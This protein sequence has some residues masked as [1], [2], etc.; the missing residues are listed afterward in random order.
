MSYTIGV[1]ALNNWKY[2][3][4]FLTSI[5]VDADVLL[6]DNGSSDGTAELAKQLVIPGTGK[7]PRVVRMDT[8]IGVAAGWNALF[9]NSDSETLIIANNDITLRPGS[10][11]KLARAHKRLGLVVTGGCRVTGSFPWR[12][13][14]GTDYGLFALDRTLWKN[15]PFDEAYWPGYFEDCDHTIRI[16]KDGLETC[17]GYEGVFDCPKGSRTI[18]EGI[19]NT[20]MLKVMQR[21]MLNNGAL[22]R[23]KYGTKN[24]AFAIA[25]AENAA[26]DTPA[27]TLL[28][29]VNDAATKQHPRFGRV[30]DFSEH[31]STLHKLAWGYDHV[32]EMGVRTAVSTAAILSAQPKTHIAY[33]I[34]EH[35]QVKMLAAVQGK[36]SFSFRQQDVLQVDIE[37]TD[38]LFIDTLHT[39]KQLSAEF[40]RHAKNV[41]HRIVLHDTVT[42][43]KKGEDK[44]TPGL[45]A[46]VD[47][48][49]KK[50]EFSIEHHYLNNNGLMVLKRLSTQ[51]TPHA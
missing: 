45:L 44:T 8:N 27:K 24:A 7:P 25:K 22:F 10:L 23:K 18:H 31:V 38:L 13:R 4:A 41:R 51:S 15:Y 48:L 30:E 12:W 19:R 28:Q 6:L 20:R 42:F 37:P 9:K 50:G 14:M 3:A 1:L 47:D 43:G 33:D 35:E 34:F 17:S 26:G 21:G 46:A 49:V 16:S 40:E 32:T 11:T 39:Y 2:T 29:Y 5:D 36:T